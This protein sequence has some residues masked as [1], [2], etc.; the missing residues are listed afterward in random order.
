[1][2]LETA[3]RIIFCQPALPA[4]RIDFFDRM[5]KRL[6]QRFALYY[7]PTDMGALTQH[8]KP[9]D[10]E[11]PVGLMQPIIPG[12]IEWQPGVMKIRM[13]RGDTLIVCGGPRTVS[14]L[15]LLV[16]ARLR[17][18]KTVWFGHYWSSTSKSHRF[19]VRMMLMKLVHAVL[20]YTDQEI[21]EYR[22]GFGYNDRRL[23]SAVNNGINV[24]PIT[25][26]R[27]PYRA[28]SRPRDMLLIG[29]LQ[30][31]CQAEMVI[32]A[33]ADPRLA[34]VQLHIV[35]DGPARADLEVL[36][37]KLGVEGAVIWHGGT[38]DENVIAKVANQCRIF[39][40]PGAVGLSLIHAMAYGLPAVINDD[41]WGN[42]PE[43]T[44]FSANSTGAAF[45]KD[46]SADLVDKIAAII[47]D[48][49]LLNRWSE[50]ARRRADEL[51][52]T[53]GMTDRVL[54]LI[55]RLGDGR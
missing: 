51:Y 32:N 22:A 18:I 6:G 3:P 31:K 15:T 9:F 45:A 41:R 11:R 12:V 10:W 46:D 1:M 37:R 39:V 50:E 7:S 24:D 28:E 54:A 5:A 20:F 27:N 42:G 44:A 40:F 49:G 17:G 2:N 53:Q 29:R 16:K 55:D 23:I 38:S 36:A 35:G 26:V 33:L 43:I 21:D 14:T 25:A 4:Y 19:Y 8:S 34:G 48:T 52:N 13:Q 30:A 47:D